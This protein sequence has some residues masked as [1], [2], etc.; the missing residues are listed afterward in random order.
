LFDVQQ[1]GF[2]V[3]G[4]D[5]PHT[6]VHV[7]PMHEPKD[8]TSKNTLEESTPQFTEDEFAKTVTW[9]TQAL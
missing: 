5:V 2:F 6:H 7:V 4:W 8:I 3:S 9:I 1:V